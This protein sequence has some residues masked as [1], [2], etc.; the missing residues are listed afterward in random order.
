MVMPLV[1]MVMLCVTF[2]LCH[3]VIYIMLYPPGLSS[4]LGRE[5]L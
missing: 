4:H 1:A 3:T 2:A 5:T